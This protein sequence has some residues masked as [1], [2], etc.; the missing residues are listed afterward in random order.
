[1][2]A[3]E[4]PKNKGMLTR[5]SWPRDD[6]VRLWGGL[7]KR[8]KG[9]EVGSMEG[10]RKMGGGCEQPRAAWQ[11][12]R[13]FSQTRKRRLP[14]AMRLPSCRRAQLFLQKMEQQGA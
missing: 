13:W 8:G 5:S 3:V 4:G 9:K 12:C 2:Q 14:C 7:V 10:E 11:P 6:G 1:M